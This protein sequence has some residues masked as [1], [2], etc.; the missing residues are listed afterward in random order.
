MV[1]FIPIC[2]YIFY[3]F[4]EIYDKPLV[5]NEEVDITDICFLQGEEFRRFGSTINFDGALQFYASNKLFVFT[6]SLLETF[7]H[8]VLILA[9]VSNIL[10]IILINSM[11]N[12]C[13]Q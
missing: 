6:H 3:F 5:T 8:S 12:L 7:T 9:I 2:I 1:N 4:I 10:P 13:V 11:P